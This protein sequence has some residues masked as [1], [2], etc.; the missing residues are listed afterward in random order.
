MS[1]GM[2]ARNGQRHGNGSGEIKNPGLGGP[3]RGLNVYSGVVP[4]GSADDA[5]GHQHGSDGGGTGEEQDDGKQHSADTLVK[6]CAIIS[7]RPDG[8]GLLAPE[9]HTR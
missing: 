9:W 8:Q 2:G 7:A 5:E 3:I 6:S 4:V 1:A